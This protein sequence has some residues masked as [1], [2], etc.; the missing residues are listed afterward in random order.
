MKLYPFEALWT[1]TP[2]RRA[3]RL[4]LRHT[5]EFYIEM[6]A[7]FDGTGRARVDT[8]IS[9][10]PPADVSEA[11]PDEIL[12]L[13]ALMATAR[14]PV[15][16]FVVLPEDGMMKAALGALDYMLDSL[17]RTIE[18]APQGAE[19]TLLIGFYAD[20]LSIPIEMAMAL[21]GEQV[22][23]ELESEPSALELELKKQAKATG[24]GQTMDGATLMR[25]VPPATYQ[26]MVPACPPDYKAAFEQ[27]RK[28]KADRAAALALATMPVGGSA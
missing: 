27:A 18:H 4:K 23:K 13:C 7:T 19:N 17:S 25:L 10:E 15:H 11:T 12:Y 28:E 6:G 3:V 14:V 21:V 16:A 8:S 20:I 1:Q 22:K 26:Y 2:E 24:V 5:D 9:H